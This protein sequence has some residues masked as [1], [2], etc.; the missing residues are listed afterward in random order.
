M[1]HLRMNPES[2]IFNPFRILIHY[3]NG[4]FPFLQQTIIP[5]G[6]NINNTACNAVYRPMLCSSNLNGV[7][8][9]QILFIIHNRMLLQQS[10][11]YSV[12]P[13][14]HAVEPRCGSGFIDV[15]LLR[16]N[17]ELFIFNPSGLNCPK[18]VLLQCL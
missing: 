4:N 6:M 11:Y 10:L 1:L 12:T 5:K 9:H 16:M 15:L 14:L 2:F 18:A 8:L 7:E 13:F 17:P 3:A